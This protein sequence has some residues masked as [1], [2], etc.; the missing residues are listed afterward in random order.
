MHMPDKQQW[1]GSAPRIR[2][3]EPS[4]LAALADLRWRLCSGDAEDE[5]IPR[6]KSEFLQAFTS[7][8][9]DIAQRDH[10]VHVVAASAE[11]LVGVLSLR[12]VRKIPAPGVLDGAWGYVTN[13]YVL[14]DWRNHGVGAKLL[15]FATQWSRDRGDELLLV[16]PS[17]RSFTFYERAGF[18]RLRD[19]LTLCLATEASHASLPDVSP[20]ELDLAP[21]EP[22]DVSLL[23]DAFARANWPNKPAAI[24]EGYVAE[25]EI[26][27]RRIWIARWTGAFAGYVT[28]VW[29]S[30]YARFALEGIPEIVDL[31][32]LPH[33]RRQGIASRLLDAAE[34]AAACRTDRVGLGF[35]LYADYGPAQSLYIRRG[36][37][38]DGRGVTYNTRPVEPGT[39]LPL[40]DNLALWC[41]KRLSP[42][43]GPKHIPTTPANESS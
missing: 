39:A 28:L 30:D 3:A 31:N 27:R 16:W 6:A 35:G 24:F 13:V 33:F 11:R 34:A 18:A 2:I 15:A 21:I 17:E 26:G 1:P 22:R 37:V 36:Y 40:D 10:L 12:R 5:A 14:P 38:P 29:T 20:A 4:D 25:Q 32:V 42:I 19:P 7:S 41:V 8:L 9:S 43:L 23:V